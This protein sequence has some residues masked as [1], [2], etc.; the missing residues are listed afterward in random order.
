[1]SNAMVPQKRFG[2]QSSP[3]MKPGSTHELFRFVTAYFV[4][5]LCLCEGGDRQ[6]RAAYCRCDS[7]AG[8][9]RCGEGQGI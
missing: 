4:P 8:P 6:G 3:G 9:R 2:K 5:R 7:W 1:M